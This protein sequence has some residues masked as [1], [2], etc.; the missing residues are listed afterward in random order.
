MIKVL[1]SMFHKLVWDVTCEPLNHEVCIQK[2]LLCCSITTVLFKLLFTHQG[3]SVEARCW[4]VLI[5]LLYM[6]SVWHVTSLWSL[7]YWRN[8]ETSVCFWIGLFL[9]GMSGCTL[10]T[11]LLLLVFLCVVLLK[12]SGTSGMQLSHVRPP[13]LCS[14]KILC[15]MCYINDTHSGTTPPY[16]TSNQFF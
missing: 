7:R 3:N 13:P 11:L 2:Q 8:E 16:P 10:E 12:Y 9:F 4:V 6:S 5:L 15:W 1:A 14:F